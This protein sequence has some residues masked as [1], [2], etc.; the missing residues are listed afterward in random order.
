MATEERWR[1]QILAAKQM[2]PLQRADSIPRLLPLG[3][4]QDEDFRAIFFGGHV[5]V[6]PR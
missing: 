3:S 5:H 4:G 1:K 2:R 6:F